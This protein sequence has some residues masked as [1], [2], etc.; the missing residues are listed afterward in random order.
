M[1]KHHLSLLFSFLQVAE[2]VPVLNF[3]SSLFGCDSGADL[4]YGTN[5]DVF[6]VSLV[7]LNWLIL[8]VP[9]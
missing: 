2:T 6:Q 3:S 4:I 7:D 8:V 1:L 5:L 9:T